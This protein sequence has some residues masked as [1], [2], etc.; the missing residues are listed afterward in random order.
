MG[1]GP[2]DQSHDTLLTKTT[3]PEFISLKKGKKEDQ[4]EDRYIW[5][6]N[7]LNILIEKI[8]QKDK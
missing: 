6:Y 1:G 2:G 8:K 4:K 7:T 5:S 3:N